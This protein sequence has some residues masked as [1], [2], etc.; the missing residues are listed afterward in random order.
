VNTWVKK[1]EPIASLHSVFGT[2]VET[3]SAPE[4]G[5]VIGKE[6]DPVCQS[7][8][9]ILH[10]GVVEEQFATRVDDGHL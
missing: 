6:M 7:G 3:Y 5:I 9:R 2:L 1:N 4:N 8:Q 10:L